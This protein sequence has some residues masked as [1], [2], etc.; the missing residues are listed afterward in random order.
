[1]WYSETMDNHYTP[2]RAILCLLFAPL[3]GLAL[4]V[5]LPFLG[6]AVLAHA[7]WARFRHRRDPLPL[8]G[9]RRYP[10]I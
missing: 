8:V 9:P 6:W 1:M 4:V 10:N 3:A 2:A 5:A 7:V